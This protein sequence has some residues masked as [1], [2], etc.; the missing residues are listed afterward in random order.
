[1][2]RRFCRFS[3]ANTVKRAILIWLSVL[4]FG[5]EVSILSAAGT[6]VVIMGVFLYNQARHYESQRKRIGKAP[7]VVRNY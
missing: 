1:M 5:N 4:V 2:K 6:V 7:P 3:V